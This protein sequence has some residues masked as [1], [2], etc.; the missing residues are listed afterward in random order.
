MRLRW[1]NDVVHLEVVCRQDFSYVTA[2]NETHVYHEWDRHESKDFLSADFVDL[3]EE[4]RRR[5]GT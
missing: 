2:R 4:F 1:S 5:Q 3:A